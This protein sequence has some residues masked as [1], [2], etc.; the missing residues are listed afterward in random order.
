MGNVLSVI[1]NAVKE[2]IDPFYI[3]DNASDKYVRTFL[4]NNSSLWDM[5]FD[6]WPPSQQQVLTDLEANSQTRRVDGNAYIL[7]HP[8][9]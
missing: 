8:G 5:D 1:M 2:K 6:Y 4:L 3:T 9:P 7:S